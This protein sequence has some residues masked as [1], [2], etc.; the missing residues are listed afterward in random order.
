MKANELLDIL[1]EANDEFIQDA[2]T[3]S[4][5]KTM[6]L[7]G[8]AKKYVVIAAS[9]ALVLGIG[10]YVLP[11]MGGG[12]NGGT[13][14]HEEGSVFMSY[15][16]PVFPLTLQ[17]ENNDI[18]AER[19][20]TM[21]FA[22]WV[23][24]WVSNEEE[25]A[26]RT[27]LTE[28]ERLEVLQTYNEWFPEGGYYRSSNDIVVTDTYTL[29]NN[30]TAAQTIRV[31][32]PF[33]SDLHG[34]DKNRPS[35]TV[36]GEKQDTK[37]HVGSYAGSFQGAWENWAQTHENPG[38]LNLQ[39]FESWEE[40]QAL[41]ADGTYLQNALAEFVDLS[42]IPVIVYEFTDD[43][44][45][46]DDDD[47]G[48]PNPTIRVMFELDYE[49]TKVLSY[50]FNG[51]YYDRENGVMGKGFSI[52]EEGERSYGIPCYLIVI[53]D[54]VENLRYQG[55]VTGGW[56]TKETVEAGVTIT[57]R[58]TNL[59]EALRQA[60]E[61]NY[62]EVVDVGNYSEEKS[63]YG[64]ELY[65]GL[66]KAHLVEYGVLSS[67][68]MERYDDGTIESLDVVGVSRVCWIEAEITIDAGES[69][70]LQATMRKEPSYDFHCVAREN[71]GVSGYDMVTA[72]G[73][74]LQI[75]GQTA[76]LEDRGQINIVR[77]NFGFDLASG[78]NQVE[79]DITNPHYYLE[80]RENET[81]K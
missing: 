45:P 14:G 32:Y 33:A 70:V 44:G 7:P 35:L 73:S 75:I 41:L 4:K 58:E 26:S 56:D 67:N 81:S 12:A 43:W 22:P 79:L 1:G 51:G 16:G 72:L 13:A 69:V 39:Y 15:A 28:E 37:L 24:V 52:R 42:H 61:C 31:L 9:L 19:D 34:I 21:D 48:I 20:I 74:N 59:E 77:Q 2:D 57:R 6:R 49:K 78:V 60:T 5:A 53:G 10:S 27:H 80:V 3:N 66:L 68:Q 11:R 25:A 62:Q 65:Y 38:S 30:D 8:K 64:F 17:E 54:D 71:K 23:P 46:K 40:Y 63:E 29:T 36:D 47:A 18:S 50:N 55:Y 76:H